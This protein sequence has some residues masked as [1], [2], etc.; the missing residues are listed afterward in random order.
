MSVYRQLLA[1][2][3]DLNRTPLDQL[4]VIPL[5]VVQRASA[6]A[7]GGTARDPFVG[8]AVIAAASDF[9]NPRAFQM[10]LGA[11]SELFRNF[12]GGI[13]FNYVN[14]VHLQRN[15]DY[16]L[17]APFVR[18]GD[19]SQRLTYG[20]RTGT[21]RPIPQL[22]SVTVR[23]S[24][25]RSMYRG[26]SFS[27]QY[28]AARKLQFGVSYTWSES[29][30]DDD[31][32][33]DATGF[34]S[35]D[36]SN[37]R[38]DYGFARMDIRHQFA[39]HVI[40]WMPL[41]FEV[42]GAFR[43]RSGFPVNPTTGA[44][45]NEEISTNDRPMSAPGV[46]LERNSFRN[47]AVVGNDVRVMKN[48]RLGNDVRRLQ[49]SVEFFNLLNLDNVVYSGVNGGLFGG[50]YGPGINTQGQPVAVD[51]RF[52][53]LRLADGTYDRTNSQSGTPLQVQFGLR[54]FF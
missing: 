39:S 19:A 34:N 54:F 49:F 6:I 38:Q 18:A 51:P 4:P 11:E 27:G 43:V 17:P 37:F 30:S 5:D 33:R 1:A 7:L 2:G 20:L 36:P 52:L 3:V 25:A 53:R 35:D 24:S 14:T 21:L 13:Q 12:V 26:L 32:E 47:R 22:S 10:G 15:H 8:A 44:D 42:G 41:G 16:N 40:Y 9:K 50:T 46:R 31:T 45:T 29:F 48:F 28:R 23:A